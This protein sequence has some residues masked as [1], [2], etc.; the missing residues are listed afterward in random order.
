MNSISNKKTNF[1]ILPIIS[2]FIGIL[3]FCL[4]YGVKIL[5]PTYVEWITG[6]SGDLVQHYLGWVYYRDTPWTFPL[7]LIDGLTKPDKISCIYTDSIPLFAVFFKILSPILPETFQYAGIWGLF[8]FAVQ[9]FMSTVLLQKFSRNPLF[10][11]P[12]SIC[13]ILTPTILQRLYGHDSL[14]AHWLI[15]AALVLWVYQEHKWKNKSTP[16][17]LWAIVAAVAPLIHIYLMAMVYIVMAGAFITYILNHKKI[18]YVLIC[19]SVSVASS[20]I[21]MFSFGAFYSKGGYTDGGLGLYSSN[22]NTF[23]NP[24]KNSAFLKPMKIFDGQ[25]EG[26][27]YLGLGLIIGCFIAL[28]VSAFFICRLFRNKGFFK[29][30]KEHKGYIIGGILIFIAAFDLAVSPDVAFNDNMLIMRSYPKI[31][32]SALSVF[33]ASGRFIWICD[34]M[35]YTA[36]FMILSKM[37]FKKAAYII[38]LSITLI[39]VADLSTMLKKENKAYN[40]NMEYTSPLYS[41]EWQK[42]LVGVSEIHY[43]PIAPN[44]KENYDQYMTLG[45]YASENDIEMSSFYCARENYEDMVEYSKKSLL[46]LKNGGGRKD[47]LYIFF[48][49]ACIPEDNEKLQIYEMNGITAGRIIN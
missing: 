41:E 46:E 20:L 26:Y 9:G 16:A 47:V 42:I 28:F 17:V 10:C 4:I 8:S 24:M 36:V 11:L 15:I 33:R 44:H 49:K 43:M 7:G 38:V 3:L 19:G 5:N 39:Q 1:F 35:I 31:I 40:K 30:V 13:F 48:D 22:L 6:R 45:I 25:G 32:V 18:R 34:Y 12:A 29:Y 23:I 2:A 14:S 27:G 21:T 37:N